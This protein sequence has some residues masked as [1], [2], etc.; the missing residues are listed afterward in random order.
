MKTCND[1]RCALPVEAFG[2][3]R[4]MSDG[5]RTLC[6]FCAILRAV[7]WQVANPERTLAYRKDNKA[8]IKV[9]S[10]RWYSNNKAR[11]L[12][13]VRHYQASKIR[14]TPAWA[15]RAKM[16]EFY[17]ASDFLGMVTGEWHHVD[18]VIPLRSKLVCGLHTEQNLRVI[19]GTDNLS[20]G[21]RHWPDMP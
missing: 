6:K 1:C 15:D 2:K 11:T 18:H 7:K 16:A 8:A 17:F 14:A 21:N 19:P 13:R 4:L 3:D 20:K 12:A 10:A 5:L 9:K